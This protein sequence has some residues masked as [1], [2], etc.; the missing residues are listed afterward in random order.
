MIN[1]KEVITVE[2]FSNMANLTLAH[3]RQLLREGKLK[4]VKVGK[5]WKITR[6]DAYS[7]LG[8]KTDLKKMEL[9]V[10]VRE[11]EEK[12]K[13]YEAQFYMVKDLVGT[14]DNAIGRVTYEKI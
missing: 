7:Y 8:I 10:Y 13:Y 2:E 11:L 4:G 1:T 3:T 9:H 12:I 5:T 14:L 6:D